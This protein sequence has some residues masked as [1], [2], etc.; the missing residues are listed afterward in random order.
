MQKQGLKQ[1]MRLKLSPQQIQFLSLLQIPLTAL[2]KR[3]E[4][5]LENN[6]ALEDDASAEKEVANEY[7]SEKP[8]SSLSSEINHSN[9]LFKERDISLQAFLLKQLPM[10]N[11]KNHFL[12]QKQKSLECLGRIFLQM[13]CSLQR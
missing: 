5:E 3:I 2:E 6:P 11:R 8:K 10:M 7:P 9:A 1:E 12:H 13:F 4:Q